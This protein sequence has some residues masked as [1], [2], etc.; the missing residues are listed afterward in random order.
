MLSLKI[1]YEKLRKYLLEVFRSLKLK[2][3][4]LTPEVNRYMNSS[5]HNNMNNNVRNGNNAMN[6]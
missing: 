3:F 2:N 4:F 1:K 6:F 5:I